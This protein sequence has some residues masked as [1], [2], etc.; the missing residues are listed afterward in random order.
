MIEVRH[1]CKRLFIIGPA[2]V[3]KSSCGAILASKLG[4][5]FCDLDLEFKQ[6][7]GD[8]EHYVK[9]NGYPTYCHKNTALFFALVEEQIQDT[10]FSIS[11]GFL[12]YEYV[13]PSFSK[14]AAALRD[15]GVSIL[16]LPS[17]SLDESRDI[18]INRI[19]ARRPWLNREREIQKF[20]ERY[21]QYIKYGDIQIFSAESPEAVVDRMEKE[22][23]HHMINQ[24]RA[25]TQE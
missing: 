18:V 9:T 23:R 19:L 20:L 8:I 7:Y 21:N 24:D 14:N 22:Y 16:L 17:R 15:L 25:Q 5:A 11:S 6:R 13:D 1:P 2:G 3:G 10:V 4:F 12:M